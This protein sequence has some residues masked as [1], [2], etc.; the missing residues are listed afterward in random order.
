MT[1]GSSRVRARG[2]N[3]LFD[4]PRAADVSYWLTEGGGLGGVAL[5]FVA[6]N[7]F[8]QPQPHPQPLPLPERTVRALAQPVS[9][10]HAVSESAPA[11]AAVAGR[12]GGPVSTASAGSSLGSTPRSRPH[13]P[14]P[15]G[16]DA[17]ATGPGPG[18]AGALAG[19]LPKTAASVAE[20]RSL[21]FPSLLC[22][23]TEHSRLTHVTST[24]AVL[25][26]FLVTESADA[27]GDRA[28]TMV[29]APLDEMPSGFK[30]SLVTLMEYGEEELDCA[31]VAVVLKRDGPDRATLVKLFMYFGFELVPNEQLP[32]W[33]DG[34]ALSEQYFF[35]ISALR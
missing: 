35:M 20:L 29:L 6:S 5:P 23:V 3:V 31:S 8:Q 11:A 26:K 34:A 17:F 9:I 13:S 21:V 10:H 2:L 1:G 16:D 12:S 18:E 27:C 30:E 25:W 24:I 14:H 4:A 19:V 32:S 33:M 28:K 7:A 15:P 22:H